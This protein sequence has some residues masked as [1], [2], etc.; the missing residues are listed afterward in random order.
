[1]DG[2]ACSTYVPLYLLNQISQ[3]TL[4]FLSAHTELLCQALPDGSRAPGRSG[5][6]WSKS[7]VSSSRLGLLPRVGERP[8]PAL[9]GL[10]M[11]TTEASP[12]QS[13]GVTLSHTS[14]AGFLVH[15]PNPFGMIGSQG[16]PSC[17]PR[18]DFLP[19]AHR[20]PPLERQKRKPSGPGLSGRMVS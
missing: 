4:H 19:E 14:S 6:A 8:A 3:K 12:Q 18:A 15:Q 1:M 13:P 2:E 20:L 17:K 10:R 5:Q 7:K 9:A 16:F 11:A